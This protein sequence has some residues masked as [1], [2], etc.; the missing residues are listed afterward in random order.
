MKLVG[1]DVYW[2]M[3]WLLPVVPLAAYA[4]TTLVFGLKG[5]RKEDSSDRRLPGSDCSERY[6][7]I[8]RYLF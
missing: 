6:F 7:R 3:Y 5:E 8:Q 4:G 1:T 2:R